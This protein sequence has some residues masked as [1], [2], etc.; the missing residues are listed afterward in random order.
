M[1]NGRYNILLRFELKRRGT[2]DTEVSFA[3]LEPKAYEEEIDFILKHAR[4]YLHKSPT[5]K[6]VKSVFAGLRPLVRLGNNRKTS[7]I[8]HSHYLVVSNSGLVTITGGKWTTYRKMGEYAVDEAVKVAH[9]ETRKSC[10]SSLRVHGY[11]NNPDKADPLYFY[12]SDAF[13]IKRLSEEDPELKEKLCNALPITKA[14]VIWHA[15]NEMARTVEDVLS[16]RTRSLLLDAKAS[17]K[18]APIVAQILAKELGRDSEWESEQIKDYRRL[19]E[20]YFIK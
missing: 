10:G 18:L 11:F 12:G 4:R 13:E 15:R 2:T 19:A 5:R 1:N 3:T 14:E 7:S 20:E 16:R 17:I 6:D 8:S 9:L